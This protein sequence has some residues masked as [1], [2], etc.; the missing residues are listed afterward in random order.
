V[1]AQARGHSLAYLAFITVCVIWGTTYLGITVALETVPVLLVAGLRWMFAGV[2]LSALMLATGRGLPRPAL[3]GPLLLLGFLMNVVGNG[4]VVYAQ[5]YVASGL[6]AVLIATTPFWSALVER[7]LPNG[8]RFSKRALTGLALGFTGIVVLVWPEM[9][10]G[11]AGGR[12]FIGGVIAIQLACVGW[13]VGTSFARRHE[14]GDNPFRS[15][16]LQMVFSG[17]ML[18]AA[19]TWNG[20]WA[21][22]SFTPRTIAAMIY[23]SI[24]GSL[25]AYSAYIYA[26]QHLPLSLVSL[27]AYINPIIAVTL[28]ALLLSEPFSTRIAISAALVLLGTWIVGGGKH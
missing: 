21:Q 5:Q 16:A 22:L 24:A 27:Y 12:A 4:F 15:T 11:G 28:G 25:V 10:N 18:L 14:L 1:I 6:T 9:T 17:T 8:E 13:V 23:L 20:D 7:L 26:I 19:A 3:W 2:V